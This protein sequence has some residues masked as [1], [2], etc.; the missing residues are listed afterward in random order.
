MKHLTGKR[1]M[2]DP[3]LLNTEKLLN[4]VSVFD[5]SEKKIILF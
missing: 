5:H 1:P 4:T 2:N 3:N